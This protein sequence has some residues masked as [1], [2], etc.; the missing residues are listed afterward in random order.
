MRAQVTLRDDG[1]W[2]LPLFLCRTTPA[3]AGPAAT[4]SRR[5]ATS[6]D[7]GETWDIV[8][9]PD[10]T[11]CV[12]MTLVP[13]GGAASPPSSAAGRPTSSTGPRA[14]TAA[15]AGR[16]PSRPTFRTT[17]RRS[18]AIALRDGRVAL[19]CNPVN[20]AQSE[21][22]RASLYDE[23]GEGDDGRADPAGGVAAIWGVRARR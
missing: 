6:T 17:T 23:L 16:C 19:L 4:T 8:E 12:H 9:V 1:A 3:R 7:R 20:A 5:V 21:A 11:G 14:T 13:L 15:E 18:S 2:M 22:R 10:S